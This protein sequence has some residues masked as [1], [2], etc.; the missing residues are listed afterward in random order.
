MV[1][2]VEQTQFLLFR[3]FRREGTNC[4][5]CWASSAIL[6]D[7]GTTGALNDALSGVSYRSRFVGNKTGSILKRHVKKEIWE[8]KRLSK[9]WRR[10]QVGYKNVW[11]GEK[12]WYE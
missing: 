3:H 5:I 4:R 1:K 2:I 11:I 12:K 8:E 7:F 10:N 9:R 6:T